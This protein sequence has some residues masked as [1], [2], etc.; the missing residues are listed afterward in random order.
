MGE[1]RRVD[2]VLV[3]RPEEKRP[4]GRPKWEENIKMHLQ[5]VG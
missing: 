5:D 4:L 3:E 2:R 1:R